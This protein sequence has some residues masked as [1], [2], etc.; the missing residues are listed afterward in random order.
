MLE[1]NEKNFKETIES[2]DI[3]L[4]D[5]YATWCGPCKMQADVLSKLSTSRAVN[6]EIVKVNVDEAP[7]LASKYEIEAIPTIIIFKNGDEIQKKVGVTE[8]EEIVSIIESLDK[9]AK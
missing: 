6:C 3:V 8:A 7:N 9:S 1:L 5:F 4:V 2:K